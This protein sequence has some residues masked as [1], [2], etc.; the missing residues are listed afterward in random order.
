METRSKAPWDWKKLIVPV[1]GILT[2]LILGGIIIALQG[3]NPLHAYY[4]LLY[5]AIGNR[6]G[7][8]SSILKTIPLGLVGL[9]VIFSYK[10]GIFNIGGEG[11]FYLGAVGA[12]VVGTLA[13]P[14]PAFLHI[15]LCI[16][17]AMVTGGLFAL[18]PGYLKAYRGFNEIVITMLLNYVALLSVSL[19]LQ[20][21]LQE[22]G[23]FY[24]RSS[25]FESTALLPPVLPGSRLHMGLV[26][27]IVLAVLMHI[28]YRKTTLG[29]R[30]ENVGMNRRAAQYSGENTKR[31]MM[32]SML[33]SGAIAGAAGAI[34]IMGVNG[35]LIE[36]FISGVGYDAI[37]IALLANLNPLMSILAAFFFGALRN[38]ANSMQIATGVSSSFVFIIQAVAVLFVIMIPGLPRL[39]RN[40]A[41]RRSRKNAC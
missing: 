23:S 37:A 38:G 6:E 40:L 5:G 22:P 19:L 20:G 39:T 41:G 9:A 25:L 4:Y 30:M 7:L 26:I 15:I 33:G 35:R 29:F 11:Q 17:A 28:L 32:L 34:E 16:L 10:S 27:L 18:L 36:N 2:G 1:I 21:P 13:L 31:L 24:N 8:I 12:T 14:I 3:V